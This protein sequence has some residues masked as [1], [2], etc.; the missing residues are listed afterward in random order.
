MLTPQVNIELQEETNV[1]LYAEHDT[2]E[3]KKGLAQFVYTPKD[4]GLFWLRA[5]L[6]SQDISAG[7]D[8]KL[9]DVTRHSWEAAYNWGGAEGIQGTN[10]S[11]RGGVD[12]DLSDQTSLTA[13]VSAGKDINV[14]QTVSHKC[15]KNW[16][17]S[18]TQSYDQDLNKTKQGAYHIGFSVT[19][20][21]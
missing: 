8:N 16:T 5:N 14:N 3:L 18:A 2:K 11:L 7:C 9:N 21:L 10:F 4:S 19:Y 12:Y 20:K 15:N 17:V 13:A 6:I 1:G